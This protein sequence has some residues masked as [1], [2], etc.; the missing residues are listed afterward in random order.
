MIWC[1]G[2]GIHRKPKSQSGIREFDI[3]ISKSALFTLSPI[4]SYLVW[5]YPHSH[6]RLLSSYPNTQVSPHIANRNPV[7]L[8]HPLHPPRNRSHRAANSLRSLPFTDQ[9]VLSMFHNPLLIPVFSAL[10]FQEP[11]NYQRV[12]N[13]VLRLVTAALLLGVSVWPEGYLMKRKDHTR[14][15]N[16]N[17]ARRLYR[18]LFEVL[19]VV[20]LVLTVKPDNV[21]FRSVACKTNGSRRILRR[22]LLCRRRSC[23]SFAVTQVNPDTTQNLQEG[24]TMALPGVPA[25]DRSANETA[26]GTTVEDGKKRRKRR[27]RRN[28][29][30][31]ASHCPAFVML[32]AY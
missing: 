5:L 12:G 6:S 18:Y 7:D 13:M 20:I 21:F 25:D 14:L 29:R 24:S 16:E 10:V 8:P 3:P 32:S 19:G 1:N 30:L 17:V 11:T 9:S 28:V 26:A 15:A 4:F 23:L 2:D 22:L 27:T 31:K